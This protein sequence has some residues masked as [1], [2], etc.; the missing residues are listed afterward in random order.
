MKENFD[1]VDSLKSNKGGYFYYNDGDLL[2][3]QQE[4]FFGI[5]FFFMVYYF[6]RFVFEHELLP[7][8]VFKKRYATRKT[9]EDKAYYLSSWTANCHHI[10]IYVTVFLTFYYP[11][12]DDPSPWKWFHDDLCFITVDTNHVKVSII[13]ASYLTYDY[14]IQKFYVKGQ[15]EISK[16]MLWH[17][18]FGVGSI[19]L[20]NYGGYAQCGIITLLL[21]V[22]VSTVF[23]NYRSMYNKDEVG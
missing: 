21:L 18:F 12:C 15:D 7:I 3:Y 8:D 4:Y 10:I 20:G 2:F 14:M 6:W 22:E 23:L 5:A 11:Q 13:T 19:L 1:I 9:E 17:H 16:Q